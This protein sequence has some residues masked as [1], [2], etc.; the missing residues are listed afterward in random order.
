MGPRAEEIEVLLGKNGELKQ[1]LKEREEEELRASRNHKPSPS[2][3]QA[4]DDSTGEID[5]FPTNVAQET[6]ASEM[7]LAR[8][9]LERER[10]ATEAENLRRENRVTAAL[11]G[12]GETERCRRQLLMNELE[13]KDAQLY[14]PQMQN[15]ELTEKLLAASLPQ[16]SLTLPSASPSPLSPP[17]SPE[18]LP[19]PTEV[20]PP[21]I[22]ITSAAEFQP[23]FR[24]PRTP[25]TNASTNFSPRRILT[26]LAIFLL[27]FLLH[28]FRSFSRPASEDINSR[29]IAIEVLPELEVISRGIEY[30]ERRSQWRALAMG[31]WERKERIARG[32]VVGEAYRYFDGWDY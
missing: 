8:R 5:D 17:P 27:A 18:A 25:A 24:H 2:P 26:M 20:P 14:D 22:P 1:A 10:R 29:Q 9:A 19:S 21:T 15:R 4:I 3:R 7:E 12:M 28:F 16:P 31:N 11:D 6:A 23:S 13:D 32:E 30:D